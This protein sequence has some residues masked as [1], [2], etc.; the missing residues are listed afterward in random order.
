M[1][2]KFYDCENTDIYVYKITYC[3]KTDIYVYKITYCE[4]TDFYVYK[5]SQC[6]DG[7]SEMKIY[8]QNFLKSWNFTYPQKFA[9]F[10]Q[11]APFRGLFHWNFE[12]RKNKAF[13][14]KKAFQVK[15]ATL[16]KK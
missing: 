14:V 10:G 13:L 15:K 3:K 7:Q 1:C 16:G 9:F 6:L 4:E 12:K 5:Y 8:T 2:I 11:N